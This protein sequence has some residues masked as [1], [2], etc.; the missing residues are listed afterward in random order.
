MRAK[1]E[2]AIVNAIK[3]KIIID[4][5]GGKV[6]RVRLFESDGHGKRVPLTRPWRFEDVANIKTARQAVSMLAQGISDG[7]D[8]VS[9]VN[10]S[11]SSARKP[12]RKN[13]A[14]QAAAR[15]STGKP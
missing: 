5:R 4:L 3:T 12:K 11:H 1:P 7:S 15:L 9:K 6:R 14:A 2:Q 10:A 13:G 8:I